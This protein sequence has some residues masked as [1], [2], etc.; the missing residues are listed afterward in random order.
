VVSFNQAFMNVAHTG[1]DEAPK[2][3]TVPAFGDFNRA[4]V[5][6]P[7]VEVLKKM[8]VNGAQMLKIETA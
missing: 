6:S 5:A 7:R 1:F 2:L 3:K 4:K 8:P